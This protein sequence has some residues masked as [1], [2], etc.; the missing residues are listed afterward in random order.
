MPVCNAPHTPG[1]W[2]VPKHL[3]MYSVCVWQAGRPAGCRPGLCCLA[4][5][6]QR[7]S[8]LRSPSWPA[9]GGQNT[10]P[11]ECSCSPFPPFFLFGHIPPR[12]CCCRCCCRHHKHRRLDRPSLGPR[13]ADSPTRAAIRPRVQVCIPPVCRSVC[14]SV[15]PAQCVCRPRHASIYIR[16]HALCSSYRAPLQRNTVDEAVP[17]PPMLRLCVYRVQLRKSM[18]VEVPAAGASDAER[19]DAN[20]G[21]IHADDDESAP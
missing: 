4:P 6:L 12:P 10:S 21:P 7:L 8:S 9:A 16:L 18:Q 5:F 20:D 2:V 1:R 15:S 11:T 19:L 14:L 13:P 3:G 17:R